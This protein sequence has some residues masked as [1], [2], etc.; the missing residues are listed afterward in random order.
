[1]QQ[2]NFIFGALAV[3]FI[4]FITMRGGLPKYIAILTGSA[5]RDKE[6]SSTATSSNVG[7]AAALSLFGDRPIWETFKPTLP[8]LF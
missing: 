5:T 8:N 1:M 3:A 4:V 2:S 7:G 6:P